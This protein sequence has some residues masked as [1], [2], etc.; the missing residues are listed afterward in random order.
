MDFP[1]GVSAIPVY[2]YKISN[3][4]TKPEVLASDEQNN[5][6]E[7]VFNEKSGEYEVGHGY[8]EQLKNQY[9]NL[10]LEAA[11]TYSAYM[12]SD[13]SFGSVAKYFQYGTTTYENIRT[14]EV[15][16]VWAHEGFEFSDEWCGEFKWL[17]DTVFTCRVKVTQ[18]LFLTNNQPYKDYID[19]TLCFNKQPNGNYLVYS[20]KQ[21]R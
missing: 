16:W 14:S 5:S 7:V 15:Y 17:S 1:K 4:C 9:G 3:I 20:L 8:S 12:Q 2:T 6:R 19:I 10:A 18:T 11:K 21:N 13:A